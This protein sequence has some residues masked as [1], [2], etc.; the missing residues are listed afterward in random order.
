LGCGACH[1]LADAGGAGAVGPPLDGIASTAATRVD[2]MAADSYML[3]S[4]INPD[5]YI[6]EGFPPGLMPKDYGD[7]I[8]EE[9]IE[10]LVKYLLTQ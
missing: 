4:I 2:G 10:L 7:R 6:V 8:S 1:T 3:K 5:D 9:K